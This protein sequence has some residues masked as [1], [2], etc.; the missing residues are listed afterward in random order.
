[1]VYVLIDPIISSIFRLWLSLK[2][3]PCGLMC[4]FPIL[5]ISFAPLLF[6]F[7]FFLGLHLLHMEVPRLK[8]KS[9]LQLPA[10]ITATATLDLSCIRDLCCKLQQPQILNPLNEA[11]DQTFI[12]MDTMSCS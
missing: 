3:E 10:Y 12:L 11:R 6:F 7:F 2:M 5:L 1:M 4:H 9:E 8:I